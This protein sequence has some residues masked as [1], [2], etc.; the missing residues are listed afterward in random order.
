MQRIIQV[1]EREFHRV[2]DNAV[3][4]IN[5]PMNEEL[6]VTTGKEYPGT[7]TAVN[8]DTYVKTVND[9]GDEIEHRASFNSFNSSYV[10]VYVLLTH[11]E[12]RSRVIALFRA[13][14]T[15]ATKELN[16]REEQLRTIAAERLARIGS[17]INE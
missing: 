4:V 9:D 6:K 16:T 14:M 5:C 12:Y 17:Q 11:E 3:V 7:I 10:D 2:G 15:E 1:G 13:G 8:A